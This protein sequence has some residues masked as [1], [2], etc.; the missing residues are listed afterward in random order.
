[1]QI[2]VDCDTLRAENENERRDRK[3]RRVKRRRMK[4]GRDGYRLLLVS[5]EKNFSIQWI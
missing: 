3:R 1:M 4:R 5:R 2:P